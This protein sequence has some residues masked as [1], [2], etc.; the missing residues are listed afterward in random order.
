MK[1]LLMTLLIGAVAIFPHF[2]EYLR[3]RKSGNDLADP[4]GPR[5]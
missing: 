2:L 1:L 5:S 4:S 3:A